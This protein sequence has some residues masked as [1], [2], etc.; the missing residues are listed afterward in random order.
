MLVLACGARGNSKKT[1]VDGFRLVNPPK[2]TILSK[3]GLLPRYTQT[4]VSVASVVRR[5]LS[6]KF[7]KD[8]DDYNNYERLKQ[9]NVVGQNYTLRDLLWI[10]AKSKLNKDPYYFIRKSYDWEKWKHS[11]ARPC[12]IVTDWRFP[13]EYEFFQTIDIN[14]ITVRYF[15]LDDRTPSLEC[16]RKLINTQTD[17]AIIEGDKLDTLNIF[18]DKF[19]QYE[20]YE[21][22][23]KV[24][25]YC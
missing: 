6:P 8:L 11:R 14:P 9:T 5:E 17:F 19:P 22:R 16:D 7:E 4:P 2:W 1:L 3:S 18:L 23:T 13:Q 15:D 10:H 24:S 20:D 21:L 12:L 25:N